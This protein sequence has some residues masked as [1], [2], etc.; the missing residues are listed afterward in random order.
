M[1]VPDNKEH[2]VK[3][4]EELEKK[5]TECSDAYNL[6]EK[7]NIADVLKK[8]DLRRQNTTL[9]EQVDVLIHNLDNR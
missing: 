9:R 5:L 3:R 8:L 4:V 6:L 7:K 2:L 1:T